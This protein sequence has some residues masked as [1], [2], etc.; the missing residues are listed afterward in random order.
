MV[1]QWGVIGFKDTY[2]ETDIV[3]CLR[4]QVKDAKVIWTFRNKEKGKMVKRIYR[5][6]VEDER[7]RRTPRKC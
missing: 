7:L 2:A 4:G 3:V 5:I 1:W 6:E